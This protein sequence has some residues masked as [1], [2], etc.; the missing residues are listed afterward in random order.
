MTPLQ[1]ILAKEDELR[2][3]RY[4]AAFAVDAAGNILLD[5][6]G[7]SSEIDFTDEEVERLRSA[8]GVIFTHNHPG[9]WRF[10]QVLT[11]PGL[12]LRARRRLDRVMRATGG[13]DES[14]MTR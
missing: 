2:L 4:E 11:V 9:G 14:R 8:T 3:L 13:P 10:G 7:G 6:V 5:K 1:T 12:E